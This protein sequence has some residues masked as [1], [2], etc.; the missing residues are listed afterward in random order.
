MQIAAW[1]D[2]IDPAALWFVPNMSGSRQPTVDWV[3]NKNEPHQQSDVNQTNL[4]II[5]R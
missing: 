4:G 5:P 3:E 2:S 1:K